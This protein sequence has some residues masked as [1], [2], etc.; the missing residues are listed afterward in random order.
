M[1]EKCK[2]NN[3][4]MDFSSI[5]AV[6]DRIAT[7]AAIRNAEWERQRSEWERQRVEREKEEALKKAEREKEEASRK[8]EREKEDALRKAERE[9]E[10]ALRKAE[11]EKENARIEK[12]IEDVGKQ[13]AEVGKNIDKNGMQI[14]AM[15]KE[16]GGIGE[17]SGKMAEEY[18]FNSINEGK[19]EM[20]GEKFDY[21][22]RNDNPKGIKGYHDEYDIVMHNG[23]AICIIEVK[24][25]VYSRDVKKTLNKPNTYKNNYPVHARKKIYLAMAGLSFHEEAEEDCRLEGIAIIK[26][27]GDTIVIEDENIKTF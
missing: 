9:K 25:R 8:A 4:K 21:V 12:Q 10:D 1:C 18:F 5:H 14:S 2:D 13:I 24:Y 6:L 16:I 27:K 7:D 20:F 26:Q 23:Q 11:R 3:T 19:K 22:V 17:S 15:Q